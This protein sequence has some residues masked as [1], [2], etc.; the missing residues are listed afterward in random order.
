MTNPWQP[1]DQ[2]FRP[3][4]SNGPGN[5]PP[6]VYGPGQYSPAGFPPGPYVQPGFPP[7]SF[8]HGYP[9]PPWMQPRKRH[10]RWLTVGLPLG[11]GTLV[12]AVITT[13]IVLGI[14]VSHDVSGAQTAAASYGAAVSS[15]RYNDAQAM[16]CTEDKSRVT[17]DELA[18]HYSNPRVIGYEVVSVDVQNFN[19]QTT[20]RAVLLLRTD[21]GLSNQINLVIAKEADGWHPCP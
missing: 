14:S 12:V 21:D 10:S 4:G 13:L 3:P 18:S 7:P 5:Y 9:P 11:I 1:S 20:A 6:P 15:G 19:G 8:A 17:P 16:L 2:G